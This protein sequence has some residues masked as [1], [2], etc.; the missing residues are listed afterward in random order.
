[1]PFSL[2]VYQPPDFISPA[3]RESPL[4]RFA[5]APAAGIAPEGYHATSIFPEYY[6]I[7]PGGWRLVEQSR[8]DCLV[9]QREGGLEAAEFRNLRKGDQVALGRAENG[10]EGILVYTEGFQAAEADK[11]KFCFRSQLTRETSF[12]IDYDELYALLRFEREQG[13]IVWVMGPAT[14]FDS[15][16]RQAMADLVRAGYVHAI[17]AGNAL[18][19]HDMEASMFG[20]ALGRDLYQK[21]ACHQGH[22]NHLDVIN[23]LRRAGSIKKAV[24]Q[25]LIEN[26]VVFTAVKKNVPLV[27]AGSIR[28]DGPLPGVLPDAY[29]AQEAMRAQLRKATTVLGMATQLH[30][31]A[32]GNMVPSYQVEPDGNVRPV[33]FYNV[34]MSEFA[35][36]KLL[37][38]GS[39]STRSILTNV[40][41]FIVTTA[42]GLTGN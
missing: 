7:K 1:M 2:P 8:M 4:V 14:V 13:F 30:S 23:R 42:R 11:E 6:H 37:N 5:P 24:K 3:L 9:V 22:Y 10:E 32:S 12:S 31:I 41:D 34:D 36:T 18:A 25:G 28:D 29:K 38:R 19:V 33:Y 40:Q 15:D 16:S 27:L 21:S 20:T 39:L 35:A 17:L 26:G